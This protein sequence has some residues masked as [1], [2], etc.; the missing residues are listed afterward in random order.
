MTEDSFYTNKS[1]LK[2]QYIDEE[3][4]FNSSGNEDTKEYSEVESLMQLSL[5]ESFD[6]TFCSS[7][8]S[9]KQDT[10]TKSNIDEV[11]QLRQDIQEARETIGKLKEE[12]LVF[13]K[14]REFEMKRYD[15]ERLSREVEKQEKNS[16]NKNR[17]PEPNNDMNL[18]SSDM[19]NERQ[20]LLEQNKVD[21]TKI[22]LKE[23]RNDETKYDLYTNGN[24]NE[25]NE[26]TRNSQALSNMR[27]GK[28]EVTNEFESSNMIKIFH[29]FQ[30]KIEEVRI[31]K[32]D[33]QKEN[34]RL[35]TKLENIVDVCNKNE[36]SLH[37]SI[38]RNEILT[39]Q[40]S[41][42][43][44][45]QKK[46]DDE[47]EVIEA[48]HVC[49]SCNEQLFDISNHQGRGTTDSRQSEGNLADQ[50]RCV[51]LELENTKYHLE[52]V[53]NEK[54]K[55]YCALYET[56]QNLKIKCIENIKLSAIRNQLEYNLR[57]VTVNNEMLKEQVK[58][59]EKE[60]E[61]LELENLYNQ[62]CARE[63]VAHVKEQLEH[64]I[65]SESQ[66]TFI[67]RNESDPA[68]DLS[69]N[70]L[71]C[72]QKF[73]KEKFVT[74]AE[75]H[76][77]SDNQEN[78]KVKVFETNQ[79]LDTHTVNSEN[80]LNKNNCDLIGENLIIRERLAV[81]M[82]QKCEYEAILH[83]I[84]NK[85]KEDAPMNDIDVNIDM[86]IS[87][88]ENSMKRNFASVSN[89]QLPLA[90]K[91]TDISSDDDLTLHLIHHG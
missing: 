29:E 75:D 41:E 69:N 87:S 2:E 11:Y 56:E 13:A 63:E 51:Q 18:R 37:E 7:N 76:Y 48:L 82:E 88:S 65:Q 9:E 42:V 55:S 59:R 28:S 31:E 45:I 34:E 47:G 23:W 10:R 39:M 52:T 86:P 89:V 74:C 4:Y 81:V 15:T 54:E 79:A 35:S 22:V 6:D 49:E 90:K 64:Y 71:S 53:I 62:R 3:L 14:E 38:S 66:Y 19:L 36:A 40:L 27:Y 84:V 50:L 46:E 85:T 58:T 32:S 24:G 43:Q 8:N 25:I 21:E 12:K 91:C 30:N 44:M 1:R 61:K 80:T 16:Y 70:S 33:L 17:T 77:V 57:D 67:L 68:L 26:T 5:P 73:E 78:E 60:F 20:V 83:N 72:N